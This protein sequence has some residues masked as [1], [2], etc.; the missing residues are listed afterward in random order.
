VPTKNG[1]PLSVSSAVSGQPPRPV[2][3][4]QTAMYTWSTSGRSSRSTFT[5]MNVSLIRRATSGSPNDSRSMTWHQWQVAYPTDRKTGLPACRAASKAAAP[6][7]CQSTGLWAC[8][9][10]YG[11]RS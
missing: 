6:H 3:A 4:W 1:S 2:I 5:G 10:R 8:C 11:L 9:S 7:G